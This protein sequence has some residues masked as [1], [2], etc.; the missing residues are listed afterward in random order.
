M[1]KKTYMKSEL[2]YS[3]KLTLIH[4]TTKILAI[5]E[6][7]IWR[8]NDLLQYPQGFKYS[9][10]CVE[11]ST[12]KVIVGFDNHYPKGSHQHIEKNEIFY[13]FID[14]DL[15]VEDFWNEVENIGFIL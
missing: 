14:T 6:I 4:S 11:P 7:K 1:V 15:L 5:C 13:E 8:I 9:L 3:S 2:I 12:G 10:F